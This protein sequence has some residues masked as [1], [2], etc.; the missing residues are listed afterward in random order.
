MALKRTGDW[1]KIRV[2]AEHA[3]E[4]LRRA[5]VCNFHYLGMESV[6]HARSYDVGN[7]TDRSK[8]LRTSIGYV[9]AYNGQVVEYEFKQGGN[10]TCKSQFFA[11][12]KIAEMLQGDTGYS[13]LLIAGMDYAAALES[14]GKNV[15]TRTE[16]YAKEEMPKIIEGIL[17]QAGFK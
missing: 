14:K 1:G 5:V 2:N 10:I 9:I 4:D 17:K 15:L 13:L 6:D 3:V 8:N 11:D 7:Y 12:A 16:R